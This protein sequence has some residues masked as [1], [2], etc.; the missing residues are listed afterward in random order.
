MNSTAMIVQQIRSYNQQ[1]PF[2]QHRDCSVGDSVLTLSTVTP[3]FV[4]RANKRIKVRTHTSLGDPES[5][6]PLVSTLHAQTI[7]LASLYISSTG[8]RVL[9]CHLLTLG[10][11]QNDPISQN[12]EDKQVK[13]L[14]R[15]HQ[16]IAPISCSLPRPSSLRTI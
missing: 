9:Y 6:L 7:P 16:F 14:N 5:Q 2:A 13:W 4:L 8:M 15:F 11:K 12:A 10:Q 1:Q 3:Q